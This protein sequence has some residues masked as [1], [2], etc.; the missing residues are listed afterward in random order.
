MGSKLTGNSIKSKKIQGYLE[1]FID[2][3]LRML[4]EGKGGDF[5]E[6]Y[7]EYLQKI[8]DRDILLAKIAN[9]SRIKQTIESY[10]K[11]CKQR[12]KSGSLMA[13]QAH[14]EL[15]IANNVQ[16]SLGIPFTM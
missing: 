15:V 9:K 12:T 8:Y 13:R 3:G 1:T 5:V 10:K 7:Y 6:Y 14:M 4:L 16:V 2:K 11:R